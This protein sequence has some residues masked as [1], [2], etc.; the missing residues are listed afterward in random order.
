[1]AWE[2]KI[3]KDKVGTILMEDQIKQ[4]L[5]AL[6]KDIFFDLAGRH[7]VKHPFIDYR[8]GVYW[9]GLPEGRKHICS[10]DR[11]TATQGAIPE[12]PVW[13]SL[14]DVVEADWDDVTAGE[15][16]RQEP[17][18]PM[19]CF[20]D[21]NKVQIVR[22][23]PSEV[24]MCGWRHTFEKLLKKKIPGVT[25][26]SLANKFCVSLV[27]E[28]PMVELPEEGDPWERE[29]EYADDE[30]KILEDMGVFEP[31]PTVI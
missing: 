4:G 3:P 2:Y 12:V 10:M 8:Q 30:G 31:K 28:V 6:N 9:D 17:P 16:L 23:V 20:H 19:P 22:H 15:L 13:Q 7:N 29:A 21:E 18:F 27:C 11:G 14:K 24:I 5:Q 26:E 1:M 25:R